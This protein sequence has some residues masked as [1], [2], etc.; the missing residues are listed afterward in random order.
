MPERIPHNS[1]ALKARFP[2]VYQEFFS[3]CA[4]VCSAPR[5]VTWV[6]EHTV[7][8]G[9]LTMRQ[10]LPMRTY[11]GIT[12]VK[13]PRIK[14]VSHT[15][16]DPLVD[17]FRNDTLPREEYI[18]PLEHHLLTFLKDVGGYKFDSGFDIHI[19]TGLP[20]ERAIGAA[21]SFLAALFSALL[22]HNKV[23]SV[24][25]IKLW[26]DRTVADLQKDKELMFDGVLRLIWKWEGIIFDNPSA[27]N[28]FSALLPSPTPIIFAAKRPPMTETLQGFLPV[29]RLATGITWVDS[30]RWWGART[31]EVFGKHVGW[32]LPF[33]WGVISASGTWL[34]RDAVFSTAKLNS[35]LLHATRF[36][37]N[38]CDTIFKNLT[39]EDLPDFLSLCQQ[40]NQPQ[41]WQEYI[42]PLHL[43]SF[44]AFMRFKKIIES[45]PALPEAQALFEVLYKAHSML[46]ILGFSSPRVE[47]MVYWL[48]TLVHEKSGGVQIGIKLNSTSQRGNLLFAMQA[49]VVRAWMP[50]IIAELRAKI[51]DKITLDYASWIDGYDEEGGVKIE[52]WLEEGIH[53]PLLAS[54]AVRVILWNKKGEQ[55]IETS[56]REEVLKK[57]HDLLFDC[58]V[59]HVRVA[60]KEC[61][62]KELPSQKATVAIMDALLSAE[63]HRLHNRALPESGY[64]KYRNEFQGK[65]TGPLVALI[66]KRLKK[67]LALKVEGTLTDFTV[68]L[69]PK[70]FDIAVVKKLG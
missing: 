12:P 37:K 22:L 10:S 60:G 45:G 70:G 24:K 43:L 17:G 29:E 48:R 49:S 2:E 35:E 68:S 18:D 65:I 13:T 32:P 31:S 53:S 55:R 52:Q 23:L 26:A 39:P 19:L 59:H 41:L 27:A 8:Y 63:G 30:A 20:F 15:T 3:K 61:T 56:A 28:P 9:G 64:T 5:A 57:K 44:Q 67:D 14:V 38:I 25:H 11:V 50:E 66:K 58:I 46:Y 1:E 47:Q 62:S 4:L 69:D 36:A 7:R 21:G 40:G 51:D 6:G 16:Y 34:L 54:D 42:K 33:D